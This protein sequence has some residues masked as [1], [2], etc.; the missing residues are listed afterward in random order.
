MAQIP[1]IDKDDRTSQDAAPIISSDYALALRQTPDG[2]YQPVVETVHDFLS[3]I[4][5]SVPNFPDDFQDPALFFEPSTSELHLTFIHRGQS[6][7]LST[8]INIPQGGGGQGTGGISIAQMQAAITAG[9]ISGV[10]AWAR[11]GQA[12]LIPIVKIDLDGLKEWIDRQ[13]IIPKDQET[14]LTKRERIWGTM[15]Q[16]L[17]LDTGAQ[18]PTEG[19]IHIDIKGHVVQL[20][21]GELDRASAGSLGQ[22]LASLGDGVTIPNAIS[23][24]EDGRFNVSLTVSKHPTDLNRLITQISGSTRLDRDVAITATTDI[25]FVTEVTYTP[26]SR[27][28]T[29]TRRQGSNTTHTS[30]QLPTDNTPITPTTALLPPDEFFSQ[31]VTADA[32]WQGSATSNIVPLNG[33]FEVV[34]G[35]TTIRDASF[36]FQNL[37]AKTSVVRNSATTN[38]ADDTHSIL[39]PGRSARI[40]LTRQGRMLMTGE[41]AT[42]LIESQYRFATEPPTTAYQHTIVVTAGNI[43]R[44]QADPDSSPIEAG[45]TY[46]EKIDID[47]AGEDDLGDIGP[48]LFSQLPVVAAGDTATDELGQIATGMVAIRKGKTSADHLLY[49]VLAGTGY[50]DQQVIGTSVAI[51]VETQPDSYV[52]TNALDD[53]VGAFLGAHAAITYI[54]ASRTLSFQWREQDLDSAVR[55]KLNASADLSSVQQF[56]RDTTTQ[57]PR[58]KLPFIAWAPAATPADLL[59]STVVG[60]AGFAITGDFIHNDIEYKT[61]EQVIKTAQGQFYRIV[62]VTQEDIEAL[63]ADQTEYNV[64]VVETTPRQ[65]L[66]YTPAVVNVTLGTDYR[67][68]PGLGSITETR[69]RTANDINDDILEWYYNTHSGVFHLYTAQHASGALYWDGVWID[70]T[71]YDL[72]ATGVPQGIGTVPHGNAANQRADYYTLTLANPFA[73]K[74]TLTLNLDDTEATR[75]EQYFVGNPKQVLRQAAR[76]LVGGTEVIGTALPTSPEPIDG[77]LFILS[78]DATLATFTDEAGNN[79]TQGRSGD[80]FQYARSNRRWVRKYSNYTYRPIPSARVGNTDTFPTNKIVF[81]RAATDEALPARNTRPSNSI[82]LDARGRPYVNLGEAQRGLAYVD[83]VVTIGG[84]AFPAPQ[85][86]AGGGGITARFQVI[87]HAT[88][89]P[90]YQQAHFENWTN[91]ARLNAQGQPTG[92]SQGAAYAVGPLVNGQRQPIKSPLHRLKYYSRNYYDRSVAGR[93]ELQFFGDSGSD[94]GPHTLLAY[95][96]ISTNPARDTE[97]LALV[98]SGPYYRTAIQVPEALRPES[99][100]RDPHQQTFQFDVLNGDGNYLY[101]TEEALEPRYVESADLVRFVDPVMIWELNPTEVGL[102]LNGQNNSWTDIAHQN[103]NSYIHLNDIPRGPLFFK[104]QLAGRTGLIN[105]LVFPGSIFHDLRTLGSRVA[106]RTELDEFGDDTDLNTRPSLEILNGDVANYGTNANCIRINLQGLSFTWV[107][108]SNVDQ[109]IA[110]GTANNNYWTPG[111]KLQLFK[112]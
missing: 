92:F 94:F 17:T 100:T 1:L 103:P 73:N 5:T 32:T 111:S 42:F 101:A 41:A 89:T 72:T 84:Q 39:I 81:E 49:A 112:G 38:T 52:R 54:Q 27:T 2:N 109:R 87:R 69:G 53:L 66:I 98:Q 107:G 71:R 56:A 58:N 37:R 46:D 23:E 12:D 75:G 76:G 43:G 64:V 62:K 44:Y 30:F 6:R 78:A 104:I 97:R 15:G 25:P 50:T 65:D 26:G 95:P 18:R 68:G 108:I 77:E 51:D 22:D 91:P 80:I 105:T 74:A 102:I 82:I 8:I 110:V 61:G 60:P 3:N 16:G 85:K 45:K 106:G 90:V 7:T 28:V 40:A 70:G 35:G 11:K 93:F 48:R 29:I 10:E 24:D 21:A 99:G 14:L 88:P 55:T 4:H 86:Y 33:N 96:S 79:A 57:I 67:G 20:D 59:D 9:I 47:G 83:E 36:T 31:A 34:V 13:D 63:P 19:T